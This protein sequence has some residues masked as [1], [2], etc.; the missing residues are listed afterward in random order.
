MN[1][2]Q[3]RARLLEIAASLELIQAGETGYTED[4]VAEIDKLSDESESLSAQI[5]AG[6]KIEAAKLKATASA[7]R[8]TA[9][10]SPTTAAVRVDVGDQ[11]N[12]R[13]GGFNNSGEFLMAVR[14]AAVTGE[15]DK[16]LLQQVQNSVSYEKVGEDGGFLVPEEISQ[17]ILKK[18][19]GD[20]S[21]MAK[22]TAIQV[23]GNALTINVDEN[24]PWNGGV[25]AYWTAEGAAITESKAAFRQAS[26]RLQKL[27]ALV[28]TTD[29]LL[30]DAMALGSYIQTSAPAAMMHQVNKAIL[31][32]NGVG[33][34]LGIIQSPF[35][36]TVS[37]ESGPQ[38]ADTVVAANVLKMYSRMFP[39][40]R[41]N[42]AWYINPAVEEQLRL[43]VDP[44]GDYIYIAP[45]GQM[46]QTPYGTLLG[47]PVIP[48]MGGIP[49][50]GDVGDIIFADLSYY[51]MIRKAQGINAQ[52]SIHLL[53]DKDQ[54]AFRFT[55]RVDGKCPFQSA[56]TTEYGSYSMSAFV[57]LEA[58]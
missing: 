2:E 57:L 22:T 33:K 32:G 4:Q 15:P 36:V 6:E 14:K 45:G 17:A 46:N 23:G 5:A 19:G 47:R 51:Y 8:K 24:Q 40:S 34:P 18:M 35:A 12:A 13:F 11:R 48:L 58:R 25:T 3:M 54:T 41:A 26:W 43:M 7:G 29:E 56:V 10:A 39:G 42:A 27:A 49:A 37:K 50:L 52:T 16:R 31:N 28:K 30:D 1:L 20:D 38:T 53:F 55:M 44:N 9:T 21:L